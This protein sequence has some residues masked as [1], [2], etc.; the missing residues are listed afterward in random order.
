MGISYTSSIKD[1]E[2]AP[3]FDAGI[4]GWDA[5]VQRNDVL[6]RRYACQ[7]PFALISRTANFTGTNEGTGGTLLGVSSPHTL[8]D[9][10]S[11]V[12][13]SRNLMY[14]PTMVGLMVHPQSPNT[15]AATDTAYITV[16]PTTGA[17]RA[18]TTEFSIAASTSS[19][20]NTT[21]Q[22]NA[23]LP[24]FGAGT[25][26]TTTDLTTMIPQVTAQTRAA[27][28]PGYYYF[29]PI[30]SGLFPSPSASNNSGSA[31]FRG[32]TVLNGT[33]SA[34]LPGAPVAADNIRY[35]PPINITINSL[36]LRKTGSDVSFAVI[37]LFGLIIPGT[38]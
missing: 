22:G 27:A 7:S 4:A 21:V 31:H 25:T 20:A 26:P 34:F 23:P 8:L 16:V 18:F 19:P 36:R 33:G 37:D 9:I 38:T 17:E 15:V 12:S 2:D 5:L 14:I 28:V 6:T 10:S 30:N 13:R 32:F 1:T 3:P 29:C 11:T 24:R 35:A